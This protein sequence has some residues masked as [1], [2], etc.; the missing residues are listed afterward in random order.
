MNKLSGKH[1]TYKIGKVRVIF[2]S[3]VNRG[4]TFFNNKSL[5]GLDLIN[6]LTDVLIRFWTQEIGFMIDRETT[7]D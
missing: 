2:Y 7:Y 4:G 6:Y 3:I 5:S 1:G